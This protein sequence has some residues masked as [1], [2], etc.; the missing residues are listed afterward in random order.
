MRSRLAL[1]VSIAFLFAHEA[2]GQR[3][4]TTVVPSHYDLAFALDLDR[5][6]FE[7]T[8]TIH[9]QLTEPTS[10]VVLHALDIEFHEVAI[11]ASGTRQTAAIALDAEATTARFTVAKPM[12]GGSA[13]IFVRYTGI[14]N[15]RLRGFY[16]SKTKTRKYAV[17]QFEA[18]D[19]RRA[20]PCFDEPAFKATFA[21]SL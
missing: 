13:D 12:A 8:E 10:T 11:T 21:I 19:A 9:V 18:T 7:G 17:T 20:F 16:I 4:P 3:L 14:L 6:R 1:A 2:R 5:E 15:D